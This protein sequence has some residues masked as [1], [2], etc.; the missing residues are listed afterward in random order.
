MCVCTPAA[1]SCQKRYKYI[2][3]RGRSPARPDSFL[4]SMQQ[5]PFQA[6]KQLTWTGDYGAFVDNLQGLRHGQHGEAGVDARFVLMRLMKIL[7]AEDLVTL[8]GLCD[9]GDDDDDEAT[10]ALFESYLKEKDGKARFYRHKM[11][12]VMYRKLVEPH[13]RLN[14]HAFL[15][16]YMSFVRLEIEDLKLPE[17]DKAALMMYHVPRVLHRPLVR[18]YPYLADN[19]D[20]AHLGP[21]RRGS[22]GSIES[23]EVIPL[24]WD[25]IC[26]LFDTEAVSSVFPLGATHRAFEGDVLSLIDDDVT[27]L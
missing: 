3:R 8:R 11:L 19:V 9:V 7:P 2:Y 22:H 16:V 21:P 4:Q 23:A 14:T 27:V 5:T 18:A 26:A 15:L 12:E 1:A 17:E 25:G 6:L 20:R 24:N 10:L 13:G